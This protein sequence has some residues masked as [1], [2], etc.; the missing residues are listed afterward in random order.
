MELR[1]YYEVLRRRSWVIALLLIVA[2]GGVIVQTTGQPPQYEAEVSMLVTPRIIAPTA[3][4]NPE[5]SDFQGDYRRTVLRNMALIV[6]SSTVRE[7][8]TQRVG[9]MSVPELK[10]R[11]KATQIP[12][13]GFFF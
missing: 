11:L 4:D 9:G 6:E 8:V 10:R 5:L 3:F 1:Y 7:R 13:T 2:V 12:G